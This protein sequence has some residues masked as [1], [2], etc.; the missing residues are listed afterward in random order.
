MT[1]AN[2][3]IGP[4]VV[5]VV[6]YRRAHSITSPGYASSLGNIGERSIAVV[7]K[8]AVVILRIR[9]HQGGHLGAIDQVNVEQAVPVV[10]EQ[11]NARR[12]GFR[13]VFLRGR[14]VL[15]DKMYA[16]F[17]SDILKLDG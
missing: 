9:L 16:S 10:V 2:K 6:A 4:S 13:L 3:Q 1:L 8:Q 14:A 12:H 15:S 7:V 11:R 5:V 17:L